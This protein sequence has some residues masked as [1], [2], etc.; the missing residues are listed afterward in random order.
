MN[1]QPGSFAIKHH[2]GLLNIILYFPSYAIKAYPMQRIMWLLISYWKTI[3]PIS[4]IS[5]TQVLFYIQ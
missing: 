5:I 3:T 4:I 1:V 2:G